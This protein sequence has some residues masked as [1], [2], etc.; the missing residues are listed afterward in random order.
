MK[1]LVFDGFWLE[2]WLFFIL[3]V[4][5]LSI[6]NTVGRYDIYSM[7]TDLYQTLFSLDILLLSWIFFPFSQGNQKSTSCRF[8]FVF[9]KYCT[10]YEDCISRP[11][12]S[13]HSSVLECQSKLASNCPVVP[14]CMVDN[15]AF[16]LQVFVTWYVFLSVICQEPLS[17][18][19]E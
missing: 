19:Q 6:L 11:D 4:L 10:V 12:C 15:Y 17:R 9:L 13:L 2:L 5:M 7:S 1:W 3:T 8:S 18:W 14:V 16:T